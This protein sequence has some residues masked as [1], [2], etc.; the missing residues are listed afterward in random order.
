MEFGEGTYLDDAAVS[1]S[2]PGADDV[3]AKA[4]RAW[5]ILHEEMS[6]FGLEINLVKGET[7]AMVG[8]APAPR[9]VI[10]VPDMVGPLL[11]L[12]QTSSLVEL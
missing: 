7:E 8:P 12:V 1:F 3:L 2:A 10:V 4:D 11:A 6:A 9:F 5:I